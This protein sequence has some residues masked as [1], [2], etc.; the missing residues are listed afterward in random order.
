MSLSNGAKI[1]IFKG[2]ALILLLIFYSKY[3]SWVIF[4]V[5]LFHNNNQ[6]PQVTPCG[7]TLIAS[8]SFTS[9]LAFYIHK[10][11]KKK[12]GRKIQ[13]NTYFL[14][15]GKISLW[16]K[17]F[18]CFLFTGKTVSLEI[19]KNFGFDLPFPHEF[20]FFIIVYFFPTF[21]EFFLLEWVMVT[22]P[23]FWDTIW[24]SRTYVLPA[25]KIEKKLHHESIFFCE[26]FWNLSFCFVAFIS[27]TKK[28][29]W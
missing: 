4:P 13:S 18:C 8:L 25:K 1:L 10:S 3:V 23:W 2:F 17:A 29:K 19:Y 21:S 20:L 9:K 11:G 28:L 15:L 16:L 12:C 22:S 26:H 6:I 7:A 24:Q 27:Q 5:R 14:N